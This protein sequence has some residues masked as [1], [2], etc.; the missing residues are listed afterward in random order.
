MKTWRKQNALLT[1]FIDEIEESEMPLRK[2]IVQMIEEI[3]IGRGRPRR[4]ED[5]IDRYIDKIKHTL[6]IYYNYELKNI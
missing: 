3:K 2:E 1:N 5:G 4:Y 6:I